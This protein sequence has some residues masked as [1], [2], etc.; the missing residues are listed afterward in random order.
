MTKFLRALLVGSVTVA[1]S[2]ATPL[3]AFAESNRTTYI[4][5]PKDGQASQLRGAIAALGEFPEDQLTLVDDLFIVDLLPEDA[6]KLSAS[7]F[8]SFIEADA[9][10]TT[11]DSQTPTPSWGLDRIDG[12]FDNSFSYPNKSGSGVLVYVFDTGVAGNHPELVGRVTQGFDVIGSNQANT[13]CHYHGTH[14]A[15]T[16]AGTVY[17]M[18][19]NATVVPI[20]VLGCTGSGSTS[21]I[22]RAINW[23]IAT[24]PAGVAGVANMSLGGSRNLSFNAAIASLVDRGITTVVAAGNSRTDACT[25]SPA[26]APEAIT[27]GATDRFDNRASFSN[28]GECVD[29]FAPG[30]SIPS[31][32]ARNFAVPVALSGTSMASPHVAGVAA[33]ILGESPAASTEQVEAQIYALSQ[34]GVVKN[35]STD[36]GNR[37]AVS[38]PQNFTPI[39]TLPGAPSGLRVIESGAGFVNFGWNAIEGAKSYQV[40]FRKASQN[41]FTLASAASAS[42]SVRELAGG[43]LAYIRVR[44]VTDAG[45]SKFSSIFSGKSAVVPPSEVRGLSI[46]ATSKNSMVMSWQ[47]PLSLGG[48][49]SIQYRVEM[50]TTGNWMSINTGPQ[51]SVSI[52]DLRIPHYFRVFAFNEAGL[53]APS[54]EM[55]FDPSLLF[56]VSS[57]TSSA[58]TGKTAVISWITD[59]PASSSFEVRIARTNGSVADTVFST[60]QNPLTISGLT[61]LSEYRVTITP[62]GTLRGFGSSTTFTTLASAPEPPR[63]ISAVKQT[64]GHLLRFA[65]P[66]DN[67]GSAI[68]SYRLEQLVDNAWVSSQTG[69]LAEFT[70]ADPARGQ[71]HDYRL[72]AINA[73]GE[74]SPS[75]VLRVTT[76]AQVSSAPQSFSATLAVDGRVNLSWLAPADDGG[77][78]VTQYRIEMLRDGAWS[79]H[80]SLSNLSASL[81]PIAKGVSVSYRVIAV[82]RA[83][84]SPATNAIEVYRDKT[85]PSSVV[86]LNAQL[87][88]SQVVLMWAGVSDN[89]GSPLLGYRVQQRIAN[90]WTDVTELLSGLSVSI[91]GGLPGESR[92]YRVLAFN[93]L[94][95][96][97]GGFERTVV[98]PFLAASAPTSFSHQIEPSRIK[99]SWER[100]T[101]LGGSELTQY[102]L[103]A[104]EDGVT[105]RS[106]LTFRATETLGY[107]TNPA[108]GKKIFFRLQ[109]VTRSFGNGTA[110]QV[111]EVTLPVIVPADPRSLTAQVRSGEGI[112][113]SW[114]APTFDGGAPITGYRVEL[115]TGST[116]TA[117]GETNQLSLLVPL[118]Q[119]GESMN[120]RV[121][122]INSAGS[123]AGLSSIFTRMGVAPATP[124]QSLSASVVSG[125]LQLS[126]SAPAAMGGVFSY[127]QVQ[128]LNGSA[129]Q[130]IGITGGTSFTTSLPAP[131]QLS[132]FR[133]VAFTNAGI[134]AFSANFD[135]LAPKV[136]PAAPTSIVIRS[137]G[138]I[139]TATWS[140]S[141]VNNGGG[142]F[143]KA[144]LYR[145]QN[146]DWVKVAEA[147]ASD[148]S[149]TFENN[150]F[151]ATHFYALRLT[152]E[153]GESLNSRTITVRHAF[154]PTSPVTNV[155]LTPE[156]T[157]LRLSWTSPTFIGGSAPSVVEVQV[158]DDGTNWRRSTLVGYT[159]T[160]LVS[161]PA[162]GRSL[163]YRVV[164]VNGGGSSQPSAVVRFDNP[165]TAPS[166]D[167][168]VTSFRSGDSV[169]FTV[170]APSD[171]GGYGTVSMRIEQQGTLAWQSSNEF[172][173][174]RP[175]V[176][177]RISLKLPP[178]RGTYTYRIAIANPS[179]EVERTVT[180]RY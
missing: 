135:Y 60:T 160:L 67:G 140:L 151:G 80:T 30:V 126:W 23:V 134:G 147:R 9:P 136:A 1:L 3:T 176:S 144:V 173:L 168:N 127:Y 29:I 143:D 13:D 88:S 162:K 12:V 146:G 37:M 20:R 155:T 105:F 159:T 35:A 4:V 112:L 115:R 94:G 165:F 79:L 131:G 7:E 65:A 157:R 117:V 5:M 103:S 49:S 53:S 152:N 26:S 163:S 169:V 72:I 45:T 167:F 41:T 63:A 27:V 10:I 98:T 121:V 51:T 123:S 28:F 33:L 122:A 133:V 113:L 16:I 11:S 154:A 96:S 111:L 100:P 153:V 177:T 150:L 18:A 73:I 68:I 129:F 149:L 58:V 114:Q 87:T 74:S 48:A 62:L 70:V 77:A 118:G 90:V 124:P 61:R 101:N 32:D 108:W 8:V 156:G 47:N 6:A 145:Q 89:G 179:G 141:G 43:E 50:K 170:F 2:I 109:A 99:F 102:L 14:V 125:R 71:S 180:F 31:A 76:P 36:R 158:S 25:A 92:T 128:R 164:A 172:V 17:G 42:F 54:A 148:Q 56:G 83:G 78:P 55:V 161:A 110:S 171:F 46:N 175:S 66:S 40:E 139:N 138:L 75:A 22:L 69:T 85:V 116:W 34:P 38:P 15:G 57:V 174:T 59:A 39:P 107:L 95:S 86:S 119:A 81:A 24:H 21:G 132:T 19:K 142:T 166:T 120:H 178:V 82:N 52:S 44:A 104:S 84:Q 97:I 130:S 137:S 91:P 64:V 93:E 106:L